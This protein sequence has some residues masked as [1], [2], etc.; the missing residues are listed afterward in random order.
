MPAE[1]PRIFK[2]YDVRGIYPSELNE[3]IAYRMGLAFPQF[4]KAKKLVVIGDY[5]TS[6][7][8][9]KGKLIEGI[10]DAGCDV[11]DLGFGPTPLMYYGIIKLGT[12][13]GVAVTASHNPPE[14]NGFKLNGKNAYP[15][16]AENGIYEIGRMVAE[17]E[18]EKAS[19]RGV[20]ENKNMVEDY[21]QN[22]VSRVKLG[23]KLKVVVD[24]GNGACA[25]IPERIL[26]ELGCDVKT[27]FKEPDGTFPNHIADPLKAETLKWLQE[28]VVKEKADLGLALDGDGDRIGVVDEKGNV[29]TQDQI[30]MI[31]AKQ[32]LE[33]RK[34][35]VVFEV[36]TSKAVMKFVEE[37][38]GKV[39]ITKVGHAYILDEVMKR[40]AVFGGELSGHMYFP[41]CY[42]Y[43][44]DGI[45]A[46]AKMAEFVSKLDVPLSSFVA[47]LPKAMATPEIHIKVKDELKWDVIEKLRER[48]EAKGYQLNTMDGVRVDFED[49]WGIVRPSNTEPMIKCR[50][51]ADN[52]EA[53]ERIK[54][55]IM[56]ELESVLK[57][58]G[59]V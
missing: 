59:A 3:D 9:L 38:G 6:T 2:A 10:L 35:Y 33:H 5:R 25:D 56:N 50:F 42:H 44:D 23:R 1:I 28:E 39:V 30:L 54:E 20:V 8:Q 12:D 4:L 37:N 24:V 55:E 34:G 41:Y 26:K 18:V 31:L 14:Y 57:S 32:A 7:P 40:N 17:G 27:I 22:I 21:I 45:F 58:M 16:Y 48:L 36:R 47:E 15:I 29:V 19:E 52:E 46:C 51:E 49:G 43:F 11:I 53:L 13:G